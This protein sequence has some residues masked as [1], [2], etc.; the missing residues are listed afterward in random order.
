MMERVHALLRRLSS[1][2]RSSCSKSINSGLLASRR[3]VEFRHRATAPSPS[4]PFSE[5]AL[6]EVGRAAA[7]VYGFAGFPSLTACH[8]VSAPPQLLMFP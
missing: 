1:V 3:V 8:D 5:N 4:R 2:V 6:K 7:A